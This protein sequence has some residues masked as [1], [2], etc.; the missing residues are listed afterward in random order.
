MKE[1]NK[2]YKYFCQPRAHA[3]YY[4]TSLLVNQMELFLLYQKTLIFT[5]KLP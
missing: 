1:V 3:Q 2:S 4:N 5:V